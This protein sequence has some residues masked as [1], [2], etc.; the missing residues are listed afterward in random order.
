MKKI[1]H[2]LFLIP[3]LVLFLIPNQVFAVDTSISCTSTNSKACTGIIRGLYY[4]LNDGTTNSSFGNTFTTGSYLLPSAGSGNYYYVYC[5]KSSDNSL[6]Y[7]LQANNKYSFRLVFKT[8]DKN[9]DSPIANIDNYLSDLYLSVVTETGETLIEDF[10]SYLNFGLKKVEL[11]SSN[12]YTFVIDI[13]P[14]VNIKS[15]YFNYKYKSS[16]KSE[17]SIPI[18]EVELGSTVTNYY[19]PFIVNTSSNKGIVYSTFNV[20]QVDEFTFLDTTVHSPVIPD[21]PEVSD[22][23]KEYSPNDSILDGLATCEQDNILDRFTCIF[24]NFQTVFNNIFTRIGN[25]IKTLNENV[26]NFFSKLTNSLKELFIPSDENFLTDFVNEFKELFVTK[27]G[28]LVYPFE[29][30]IDL[31][32]KYVNI[33]TDPIIRIPDIKEPFNDFVIIEAREFNIQEIF[34]TG[35]FKTLYDIYMAFVGCYFII[36]FLNYCIK[37]YNEFVK[38]RGDGF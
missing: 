21:V 25:A 33:E 15:L 29:V 7:N 5:L 16:E 1:K 34:N 19:E 17:T 31:L 12:E 13:V 32:D 11:T 22:D 6:N 38:A 20:Y 37:K 35:N 23:F 3:L 36:L 9:N 14:T 30:L 24:G 2:F 26:I 8:S 18:E 27:L 28:F 4:K 10:Y